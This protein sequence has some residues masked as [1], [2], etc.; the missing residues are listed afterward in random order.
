MSW[1]FTS[2]KKQSEDKSDGIQE[3]ET[4]EIELDKAKGK[5]SF[6]G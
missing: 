6:Q 5:M 1:F 4:P 3:K 2:K